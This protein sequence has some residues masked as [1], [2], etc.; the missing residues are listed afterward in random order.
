MPSA[1]EIKQE[2]EWKADRDA[3]LLAEANVI[4]GDDKRLKAAKKA[5]S[6]LAKDAAD[7]LA[8]LLRVAGKLDD[9]VEGMKIH[10]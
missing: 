1:Q 7:Q 3:E 10:K 5:A 2:K 9:K 6:R 4:L 8:G